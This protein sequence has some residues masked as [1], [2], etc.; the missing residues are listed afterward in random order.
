MDH[1]FSTLIEYFSY[2][3]KEFTYMGIG[4]VPYGPL[5]PQ[6]DQLLPVFVMDKSKVA[7]TRI[8]HFDPFFE[9]KL[10]VL[11][12]YFKSRDLGLLYDT[13]DGFHRWANSRMEII[14]LPIAF[15]HSTVFN[16]GEG[17]WFLELLIAQ[18]LA[19][20]SMLVVQEFTGTTTTAVFKKLYEA[21]LEKEEFKRRILF[22]ITYGQ[23][24][25]CMTDLTKY[26]PLYTRDGFFYNFLLY[27]DNEMISCIGARRIINEVITKHFT[28]KY[29][30][31]LNRIHV[32]YRRSLKGDPP[33]TETKE[34]SA[35]T[36]SRVIM[37]LLQKKLL[38]SI[39][40]FRRLGVITPEKDEQITTLFL[41]YE[42]YDVYK[43]YDAVNRL[44]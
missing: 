12:D 7:T 8:I 30:A 10:D 37:D 15:N 5:T 44:V 6:N 24:E 2:T 18:T 29:K 36:P 33:L 13:A 22:D 23:D 17:D 14:V 38:E 32:D 39:Q 25:G 34:Y 16:E 27:S 28:R 31:D 41:N 19:E 20:R 43:W 21:S 3:P 9:S 40:I 42:D 1:V 11:H 4:T 26:A 35:T